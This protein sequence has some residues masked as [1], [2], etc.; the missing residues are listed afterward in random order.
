[1]G[2]RSH[3]AGGSTVSSSADHDVGDVASPGLLALLIGQEGKGSL[4]Q[5]VG[6]VGGWREIKR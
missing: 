6:G 2:S 4:L 5:L 1:M 3:H